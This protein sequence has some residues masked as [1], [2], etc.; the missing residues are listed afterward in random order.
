MKLVDL[1]LPAFAFI[2]DSG[3]DGDL[4]EGRNVIL[5]V[6]SMTV[7]EVLERDNCFLK[8]GIPVYKFR[9]TNK[10]GIVERFI[11]AVH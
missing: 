1:K 10:Y 6:R 9:Y 2:E 3:H 5:H 8:E 7:I 11:M 4:L